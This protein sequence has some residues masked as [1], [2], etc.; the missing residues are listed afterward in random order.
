MGSANSENVRDFLVR[1]LDCRTDL[2]PI[3]GPQCPAE[4]QL[5]TG[6]LASVENA[7]P[8]SSELSWSY[9]VECSHR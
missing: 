8:L 1:S 4:S 5:G 2:T 7:A 6:G 9:D 3:G